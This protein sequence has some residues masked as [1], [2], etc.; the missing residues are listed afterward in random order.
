MITIDDIKNEISKYTDL[1]T[2]TQNK[3]L[4]AYLSCLREEDL[5]EGTVFFSEIGH[6]LRVAKTQEAYQHCVS[7][8]MTKENGL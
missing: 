2:P 8:G 7:L 6:Q 4:E 3:A 5:Y 1:N